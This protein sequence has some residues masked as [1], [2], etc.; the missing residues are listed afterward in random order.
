VFRSVLQ[1]ESEKADEKQTKYL[2]VA[3]DLSRLHGH[4]MPFSK[5]G[6]LFV[7]R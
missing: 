2:F 5:S 1:K 4:T 6:K 3:N 7:T